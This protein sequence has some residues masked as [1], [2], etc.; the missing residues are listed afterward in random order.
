MMGGRIW[1]ESEPGAG[2]TFHFTLTCDT[3]ELPAQPPQQDPMLDGLP[4]LVVDDNAI[5]RRILCEQVTRWQM[6]PTAVDGGQAA[7]EALRAAAAA[8]QPFRLVLL[9]ANM[10][11][12]DGFGVAKQISAQPELA[13][14][15]IMMLTSSGQYGDAA[16]CQ[17]AGIAAYLTK[18]VRGADLFESIVNSLKRSSPVTV[19]SPRLIVPAT[20]GRRLK[21]LLAEDN[22]VNQRVAIGL[23]SRRGHDV[24][25]AANGREAIAAV[26]RD[27]FDVVLM[28]VQMP[29]M[30]GFEA[31]EAI[32]RRERET[33]GHL[34]II[35]MTAH[36]MSGDE[37][38]CLAAGMDGYLSKPIDR[39]KL[40][41]LVE[42]AGAARE[43]REAPPPLDRAG[44]LDR[45]GGDEQLLADVVGL[46]LEDCPAQLAALRR[47]VDAR[48][49]ESIRA[50]AHALK[51]AAGNLSAHGLCEAARAMEL[52][53]AE[54]NVDAAESAWQ[55]LSA[56]AERVMEALGGT[57]AR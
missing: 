57:C 2:S 52:I 3:A 55:L 11:D 49:P 53:G 32:R 54:R 23:L 26:E 29:E 5:N 15:T 27:A 42:N 48:D 4:V 21:I 28:D 39:E 12:L 56:E 13:G 31:T 16:K 30:G 44:L 24:T 17:D 1:V 41:A 18:P 45:L 46:F 25:V 37:E 14:A 22:V 43:G 9:D 47:A 33:G 50:A 8:G 19:P 7:L 38:R 6:T 20:P 36:A 10:P 40:F 35:A 34:T 51:G